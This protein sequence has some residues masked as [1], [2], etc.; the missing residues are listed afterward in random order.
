MKS[1]TVGRL[2]FVSD[3]GLVVGVGEREHEDPHHT[4]GRAVAILYNPT[5]IQEW[6]GVLFDYEELDAAVET[7]IGRL[8]GMKIDRQIP[9]DNATFISGGVHNPIGEA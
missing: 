4:T 1:P 6:A 2:A 9:M 8:G 5:S 3:N 7:I